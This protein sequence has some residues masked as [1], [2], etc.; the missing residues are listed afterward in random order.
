MAINEATE[1][2]GVK[3]VMAKDLEEFPLFFGLCVSGDI[4]YKFLKGKNKANGNCFVYLYLFGNSGVYIT[5]ALSLKLPVP[6]CHAQRSKYLAKAFGE[7][8]G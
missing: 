3:E 7:L 4:V 6:V 8:V 1:E 5:W 2:E